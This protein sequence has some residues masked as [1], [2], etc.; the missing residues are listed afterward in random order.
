M[1]GLK[2][3]LSFLTILPSKEYDLKYIADNLY[4]FPIAGL[5]IGLIVGLLAFLTFINSIILALLITL[6][7]L[8]ITGLHHTDALAD[9]ADG[10][11]VKGDK[12]V[13]QRVMH[14]PS[15]GAAGVT[16]IA[17]YLIGSIISLSLLANLSLFIAIVSSEILAKYAMVLLAYLGKP[18]WNGI[19]SL[20]TNL[21]SKR[22]AISVI[23]TIIMIYTLADIHGI[24]AF[25]LTS[26]LASILLAI[27]N[28]SFGGI[29]G[30]VFG[31]TNEIVRLSNFILFAHLNIIKPAFL[32]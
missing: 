6:A 8:I 9:F 10:L 2:A 4:L 26:I 28:R 14:D 3:I 11:M 12:E 22:F 23:I 27:A 5:I 17:L 13:K 19:G 1:N 18:A 15:T 30:D 24:Y 32:I 16:A 21:N 29:S 7:L 20:F 31:A 25:I